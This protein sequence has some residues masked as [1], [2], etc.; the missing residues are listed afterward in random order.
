MFNCPETGLAGLSVAP[1]LQE[2]RMPVQVVGAGTAVPDTV[3]A[4]SVVP[5]TLI[6][7]L[8]TSTSSLYAVAPAS[9]TGTVSFPAAITYAATG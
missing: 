1:M 5:L 9:A 7:V 8:V 4:V 6:T 2:G 3:T